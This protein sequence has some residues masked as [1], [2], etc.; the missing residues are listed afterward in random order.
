MNGVLFLAWKYVR[1]Y[2]G[3]TLW[4]VSCV[5]LTLLLPMASRLM[6]DRFQTELQTRAQTTPMILGAKGSRF[7][8]AIHALHFTGNPPDAIEYGRVR[9]LQQFDLANIIPV[10]ARFRTR[11]FRSRREGYAIVGT[12]LDYFDFRGLSLADGKP[13]LTL[14]ECVLGA[15]VA[16]QQDIGVGDI[17]M[18][19]TNSAYDLIASQPLKMRVVGVLEK[20]HTDDDLAVFIDLKTSWVIEGL[21]HGHED[22]ETIENEELLLGRDGD[23]LVASEAVTGYLEITPENSDSFHFHGEIGTFPVTALI[24]VPNDDKDGLV[25]EGK[26]VGKDETIQVIQPTKVMDEL[27]Q[28]VFKARRFFDVALV[29][30]FA[31]TTLFLALVTLMSRQLRKREMSTMFKIGCGPYTMFWIQAIELGFIFAMSLFLAVG[32]S[33]IVASAASP[34]IRQLVF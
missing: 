18:S 5:G 19:Q 31:I 26:F 14:G 10:H 23:E 16:Q 34:L 6:V 27:L 8:L 33:M 4:L 7:E 1:Y 12:T 3:R 2:R 13:F 17:V 30:V 29:V 32:G 15:D 20:T 9:E 25:F 24:A 11:G 22:L 28:R 21:G